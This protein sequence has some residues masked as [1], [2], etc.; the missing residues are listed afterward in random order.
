M[1]LLIQKHHCYNITM[2]LKGLLTE[3]DFFQA[4]LLNLDQHVRIK[5]IYICIAISSMFVLIDIAFDGIIFLTYIHI[6]LII[7][8]LS[9]RFIILHLATK[10][11]YKDSVRGKIV[12]SNLLINDEG[13]TSHTEYRKLEIKWSAIKSFTYNKNVLFLYPFGGHGM[14]I[15]RSLVSSDMQWK[16]LIDIFKKHVALK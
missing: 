3:H 7:S 16:E 10:K 9:I 1:N 6:I 8:L 14:F 4:T 2:K 12:N 13:I 5:Y 15:S 11:I